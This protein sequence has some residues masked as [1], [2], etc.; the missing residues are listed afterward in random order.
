[1]Q[2]IIPH[3]WFDNQAEKIIGKQITIRQKIIR[4]K[5]SQRRSNNMSKMNPVVHFEMLAEDKPYGEPSIRHKKFIE[6]KV[7]GTLGK[8]D[9]GIVETACQ[10]ERDDV[11]Q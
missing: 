8:I 3:L 7:M 1:M 6:P 4:Q 11:R 5:K 2:K 9:A 10:G